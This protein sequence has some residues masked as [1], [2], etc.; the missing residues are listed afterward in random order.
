M[1]QTKSVIRK[2]QA[3][4]KRKSPI[5]YQ[6]KFEQVESEIPEIQLTYTRRRETAAEQAVKKAV[7]HV[8]LLVGAQADE[9]P[10]DKTAQKNASTRNTPIV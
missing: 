4:R 9:A 7:E 1:D 2:P 8:L 5:G 3:S 10:Q 6:K